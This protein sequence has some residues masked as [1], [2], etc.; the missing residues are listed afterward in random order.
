MKSK[1]GEL[2]K[3]YSDGEIIIRQGDVGNTMHVIQDGIVDV[4]LEGADGEV[5]L[6]TLGAGDFVGEMA[7]FDRETRSATV[8]AKGPVRIITIDKKNFLSRVHADP[9]LAFRLVEM[10]SLRIRELEGTLQQITAA[11]NN[12]KTKGS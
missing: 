10:M 7:L 6:G 4:Y 12:A 9:S 11:L 5:S 3:V 2:G 1:T 8:R